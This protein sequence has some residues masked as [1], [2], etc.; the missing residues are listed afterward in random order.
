MV[1][2]GV[3]VRGHPWEP[4]D[5]ADAKTGV[6]LWRYRRPLSD[7]VIQLHRTSRGVG[8]HNKVFFAAAEAALVAL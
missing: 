5:R 2:N 1:N 4:G 3:S 6:Q 8:P 7:E